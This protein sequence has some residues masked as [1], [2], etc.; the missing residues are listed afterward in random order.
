MAVIF[1]LF[2]LILCKLAN[3]E[4][5]DTF[6]ENDNAIQNSVGLNAQLITI[7]RVYISPCPE[8]YRYTYNG[9]EWNGLVIIKRPTP[10]GVTSKIKIILSIGFHLSSVSLIF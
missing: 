1:C 10:K 5:S 3:N 2:T 9:K 8:V 6:I 7:P 4:I